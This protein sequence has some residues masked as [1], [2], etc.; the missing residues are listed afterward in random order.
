MEPV[1][2][3]VLDAAL[4]ILKFLLQGE[5][6]SRNKNSILYEKYRYHNDV[7]EMLN[8]LAG[9]LELKVYAGNNR[10]FI[11]LPTANYLPAISSL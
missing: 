10:L 1:T 3:E 4:E 2:I 11:C 9:K 6:V 7:E 5:E 8:Y